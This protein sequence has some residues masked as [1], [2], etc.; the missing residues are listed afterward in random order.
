MASDS[1]TVRHERHCDCTHWAS[2]E[3]VMVVDDGNRPVAEVPAPT[4]CA[5]R[6]CR[7]VRPTSSSSTA[8][9]GCSCSDAPR[10]RTCTRPATTT[11][12][13]AGS[14]PPASRTRRTRNARAE[15][16]LGIRDTTLE[17]EARLL[18]R[19]RAQPLLRARVHLRARRTVHR[20]RPR[21]WKAW[22]STPSR[23]SPLAM[24]RPSLPD[25]PAR[26]R[27]PACARRGGGR[28]GVKGPSARRGVPARIDSM[29]ATGFGVPSRYA[30][31]AYSEPP[32]A[33]VF[34]C[35]TVGK[36]RENWPRMKATSRSTMTI[37]AQPRRLC[38][39]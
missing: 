27:P 22:P 1:R 8:R 18:P 21:R 16:E 12:P 36:A 15:E 13:Q 26:L 32:S 30:P 5:A 33:A 37:R 38:R 10:S 11:S 29:V 28:A 39:P 34:D 24:S 17:A 14:S 9:D 7:I 31:L 25:S 20:S 2:Q 35:V 19:G 6:T 3:I 4:A 23:R